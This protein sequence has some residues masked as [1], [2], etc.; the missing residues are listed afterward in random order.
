MGE[1]EHIALFDKLGIKNTRQRNLLYLIL[2]KSGQPMT[3]EQLF[4]E[5]RKTDEGVSLS[6]IYR[7][8]DVFLDKGLVLKSEIS[9][10][11]KA[12]FELDHM[13]HKHH[14]ICLSCRK[15]TPV[16]NC[17]LEQFEES[18]EKKTRYT[19]TSHKLE[20][21][22]YCPACINKKNSQETH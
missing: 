6:T 2:E 4:F 14:L 19:I 8:L 5:V 3:A 11:G 12:V 16:T 9:G 10:E 17:P 20:I 13:E 15:I 1:N 7:I 22:G 18:L 21:Y